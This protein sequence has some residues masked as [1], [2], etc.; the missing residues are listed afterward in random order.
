MTSPGRRV[1]PRLAAAG[2]R[3]EAAATATATARTAQRPG[4][5]RRA[6]PSRSASVPVTSSGVP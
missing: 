1:A 2:R 6:R 3:T 4:H 5:P